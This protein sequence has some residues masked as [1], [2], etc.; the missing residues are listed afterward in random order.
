MPQPT[1][2]NWPDLPSEVRQ[3][4]LFLLIR[5]HDTPCRQYTL[6][7]TLRLGTPTRVPCLVVSLHR[8]SK[9][10][11]ADLLQALRAYIVRVRCEEERL[12]ERIRHDV[13]LQR[14]WDAV[15]WTP[16]EMELMACVQRGK[17]L[18]ALVEVL[19][20]EAPLRLGCTEAFARMA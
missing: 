1:P 6:H 19:G 18:R 2:T 3:N 7:R 8:V 12:K 9:L 14:G 17:L 10:F 13:C 15:L 11:Q 20:R 16:L 5:A 4:I